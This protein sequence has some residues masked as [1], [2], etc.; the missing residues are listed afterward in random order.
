MSSRIASI[1]IVIACLAL[2]LALGGCV[3]IC[4]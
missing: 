1:G 4:G 2:G 3:V